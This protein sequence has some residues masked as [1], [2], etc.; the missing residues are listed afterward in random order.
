MQ[1]IYQAKENQNLINKIN[2]AS[3]SLKYR[4]TTN[5][6]YIKETLSRKTLIVIPLVVILISLP[7]L[8]LTQKYLSYIMAEWADAS[9]YWKLDEGYGTTANDSTGNGNTGTISGPVWK[10]EDLCIFGKCLYFDGS[11]DVVT[12]SATVASINSVSFWVKPITTTEQFIDLNGSAYIQASSGTVSA[13]GFTS[14]TI[15][16]NGRVSSTIVANYWQ[17]VT[18]TTATDLSGSAIKLGQIST[19]YGQIFM[20]EI[21]I[22]NYVRTA[23]QIKAE[24]NS[25]GSPDGSAAN[26]GNPK[27]SAAALSNGLFGY[28]R[29]DETAANSCSGGINDS[30]DSSG[31]GKDGAWN[32]NAANTTGKFG[33]GVTFDGT[34]DY[35]DVGDIDL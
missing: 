23:D 28:W 27:D 3:Q 34:G 20:D 30:C 26:F 1:K 19:N 9:A 16:V 14:P 31:N 21:R 29:M 4:L 7:L 24:F 33:N 11:N 10:T 32:G 13:T 35:I 25:L 15:Y 6:L 22:Y 8:Y 17:Y 18:V 12:V 2:K 5:I